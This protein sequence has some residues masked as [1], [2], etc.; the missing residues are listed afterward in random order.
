MST[1]AVSPAYS[2]ES[3]GSFIDAPQDPLLL[4]LLSQRLRQGRRVLKPGPPIAR[5]PREVRE[6]PTSAIACYET[7]IRP[8]PAIDSHGSDAER[9]GRPTKSHELAPSYPIVVGKKSL[10]SGCVVCCRKAHLIIGEVS[11]EHIPSASLSSTH[12]PSIPQEDTMRSNLVFGAMAYVSNRYLLTR[13]ASKAIRKLHR[14][15]TRIQE[16]TNDVLV[17][18]SRASPIEGARYQLSAAAPLRRAS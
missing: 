10:M 16:T 17:R 7:L 15:S 4:A 9:D 18:F 2:K 8:F 5:Q 12:Q 6:G 1:L 13:L 11:G 14:P 3:S